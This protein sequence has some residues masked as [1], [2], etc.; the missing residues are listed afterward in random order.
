M[1]DALAFVRTVID[2]FLTRYQAPDARCIERRFAMVAGAGELATRFG[3]TG[4]QE[5]ESVRQ[6]PSA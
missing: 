3:I 1:E 2:D 5:G 6:S 4:W